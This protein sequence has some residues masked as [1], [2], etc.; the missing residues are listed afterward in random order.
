MPNTGVAA[1]YRKRGFKAAVHYI[2]SEKLSLGTYDNNCK[3]LQLSID[4]YASRAALR[5]FDRAKL[6]G[7]AKHSYFILQYKDMLLTHMLSQQDRLEL[8]RASIT[9]LIA[10]ERHRRR[11]G[12]LPV[13]LDDINDNII[14]VLPIDPTT[15][16]A[17]QYSQ[18]VIGG[19]VLYGPGTDGV[20]NCTNFLPP[21]SKPVITSLAFPQ[22]IGYY[23][24]VSNGLDECYNDDV[25]VS[26]F[27]P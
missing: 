20:D 25:D 26:Q 12:K 8:S 5:P 9:V 10:I 15:G 13:T 27:V 21:F 16:R 23:H 6:T 11:T 18:N 7:S 14:T 19:Y 22:L 24:T 4:E 2:T 1:I 3:L 17:F